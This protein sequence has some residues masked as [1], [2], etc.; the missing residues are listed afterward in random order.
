MSFDVRLHYLP[1]HSTRTWSMDGPAWLDRAQVP[2]SKPL[3]HEYH[4]NATW[5]RDR[6][7]IVSAAELREWHRAAYPPGGDRTRVPAHTAKTIAT[8]EDEM[9]RARD[10][11]VYVMHWYEW[12]SG[13]G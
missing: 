11:D 13:M 12:E 4:D 9:G 10:H 8:F 1:V 2:E 5:Q 7:M 3:I 6:Y